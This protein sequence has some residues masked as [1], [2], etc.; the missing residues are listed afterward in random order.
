MQAALVCREYGWT[1]DEYLDQP[2]Y[3]VDTVLLMLRNEAQ[4]SEWRAKTQNSQ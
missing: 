2:K 1:Y 4:V 3:F